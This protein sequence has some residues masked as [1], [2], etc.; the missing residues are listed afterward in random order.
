MGILDFF[1]KPKK[2]K[3]LQ[4]RNYAAAARNRLMA[5]FIGSN[6]S[7]DSEIR[8]S[9]KELRNRSRDLERNNEYF[10]RYL[11]LLQTNVVGSNGFN[12]QISAVN[13]DG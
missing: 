1:S 6:R 7:A 3:G 10:R 13:P 5:D 4:R 8:W 11:Q 12:L 9:L 2:S